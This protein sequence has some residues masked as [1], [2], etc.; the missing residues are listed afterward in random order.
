[1]MC[2]PSLLKYEGA[3]STYEVIDC[4]RV[5]G[6]FTKEVKYCVYFNDTECEVKCTCRLFEFRGI[7]CR[8]ALLF[9]PW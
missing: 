7:M 5:N 2:L 4:V 6:D 3:I 1:M 9:L 8:N